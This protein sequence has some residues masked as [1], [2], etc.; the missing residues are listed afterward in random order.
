MGEGRL[1]DISS[2]DKWI[3]KGYDIYAIGVQECLV[4]PELRELLKKE[5]GSEYT[6]FTHEIGSTNTSLG[7]HG[8]IALTVFARTGDVRAGRFCPEHIDELSQG[9]KIGTRRMQN[10][11]TVGLSFRYHDTSL[12]FLTAHLASDSNGM[13]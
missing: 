11:G 10:K 4:L 9:K 1:E 3:P 12:A 8:M 6:M 5:I 2:I 7:F 13:I